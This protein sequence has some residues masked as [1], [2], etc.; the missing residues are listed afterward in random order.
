MTANVEPI[1]ALTP[2]IGTVEIHTA[3]TARDGSGTIGTVLTGGANGT[4]VTRIIVQALVTTTAGVVRLFIDSGAVI[5]LWK[6]ILVAA[7][8]GSAT[9]LE[10]VSV[11][12]LLGELALVLPSG[13]ILMASTHNAESFAIIAEGGDY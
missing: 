11:L 3:N 9:V 1:F 13:Y 8:T 5:Y 2:V 4:R 10:F 12:N 6:E 7:I